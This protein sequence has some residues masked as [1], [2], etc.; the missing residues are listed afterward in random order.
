MFFFY[1]RLFKA[2]LSS[3]LLP[4]HA[5]RFVPS[6]SE[7]SEGVFEK[8]GLF[9]AVFLSIRRILSCTPGKEWIFDPVK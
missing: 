2:F 6:C 4:V 3:V 9:K 8:Y 7:Y 5:C 1:R